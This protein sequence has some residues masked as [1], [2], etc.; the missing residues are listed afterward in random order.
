MEDNCNI[1]KKRGKNS[2]AADSLLSKYPILNCK[3]NTPSLYVSTKEELHHSCVVGVSF[4]SLGKSLQ[5]SVLWELTAYMWGDIVLEMS[6]RGISFRIKARVWR[7]K[8]GR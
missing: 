6:H 8:V 4:L 3:K 7:D 1:G 5:R 2:D